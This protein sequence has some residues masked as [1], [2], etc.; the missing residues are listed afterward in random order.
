M[1]GTLWAQQAYIH[2]KYCTSSNGEE[3]AFTGIDLNRDKL[4][5][6][7]TFP[8][9]GCVIASFQGSECYAEVT[10]NGRRSVI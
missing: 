2:K 10:N 9:Q 5:K 7:G 1:A 4:A 6:N 8:V 3:S